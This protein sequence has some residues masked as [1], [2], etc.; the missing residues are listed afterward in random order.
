MANN[1]CGSFFEVNKIPSLNSNYSISPTDCAINI[2]SISGLSSLSS[3]FQPWPQPKNIRLAPPC[4]S[5]VLNIQKFG[6]PF[7]D[8]IF[9]LREICTR[10]TCRNPSSSTDFILLASAVWRHF[11]NTL[12]WPHRIIHGKYSSSRYATWSCKGSVT[13]N[14]SLP[15]RPTNGFQLASLC[16]VKYHGTRIPK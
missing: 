16:A 1:S 2:K 15:F 14:A 3:T 8:R 13:S 7:V 6:T 4:R 11:S 12:R 9:S 5:L 10:G